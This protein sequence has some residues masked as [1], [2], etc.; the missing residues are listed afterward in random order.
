MSL[1]NQP[2]AV[3]DPDDVVPRQNTDRLETGIDVLDE[4]LGGGIVPGYIVAFT[5]NPASQS[6]QFLAEITTERP[7]LYVTTVRSAA[8]VRETLPDQHRTVVVDLADR[9]LAHVLELV[10]AVPHRA[11]VVVDHVGPLEPL[12]PRSQPWHSGPSYSEFLSELRERLGDQAGVGYLHCLDGAGTPAERAATYH[13]ADA[14]FELTT[15]REGDEITHS[16]TVP[17]YRGGS[18]DDVIRLDVSDGVEV[19]FSRN[20]V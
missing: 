6:E 14:V 3:A 16:L 2:D 15:R 17:K 5:G 11:H 18:L 20:I 9:D 1:W 19:D 8:S 7:T 13:L 4:K 10:S 12:G